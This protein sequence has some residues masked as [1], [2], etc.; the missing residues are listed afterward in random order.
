MKKLIKNFGG[1]LFLLLLEL[2]S[3]KLLKSI[4][5]LSI[6]ALWSIIV[7]FLLLSNLFGLNGHNRQGPSLSMVAIA[8]EKFKTPEGEKR[9]GG[10]FN[11]TNYTYLVFLAFNIAGFM[12]SK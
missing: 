9:S 4:D 2:Y 7:F 12:I 1:G 8:E 6:F 3:F 11:N 10:F 5:L